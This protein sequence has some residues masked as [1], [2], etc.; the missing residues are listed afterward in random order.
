[1]LLQLRPDFAQLHGGDRAAAFEALMAVEGTVYREA[2]GRSTRQF[3]NRLGCFFI[4]THRGVGWVEILKNI[5]QLRA[6]VV[7]ARNEWKA[8]KR[9]GELG[10]DTMTL[11]GY[12]R[13][14]FIP[15]TMQSFVITEEITDATP[16]S[17]VT[18]DWCDRGPD[19][20]LKRVLIDK[21]ADI[22]RTL[23]DNGVNHRDLYIC[24]FLLDEETRGA[25]T[26]ED[27][28]LY[29][30]DLHRVQI[31]RKTP[32]R[33]RVKDVAAIY[34]SA[35]DIGLTR[36]DLLRFVRRYGHGGLRATLEKERR[37]W[38]D[39]EARAKRLY[40]SEWGRSAS[41]L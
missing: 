35:M 21:I 39:V 12:G 8:I 27:I 13:R 9:L 41:S 19:V 2:D 3:S 38:R 26:A 14:G 20:P 6:P 23:H 34:F 24:H 31:R 5:A 17:D 25:R 32:Y 37:F 40:R 30:I 4:K 22:A 29:L 16:L 7:G 10:V 1:M 15:S 36:R 11:V 33:W 28:R 18:R